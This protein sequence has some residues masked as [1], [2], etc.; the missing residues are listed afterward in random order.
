MLLYRKSSASVLKFVFCIKHYTST[1]AV[2]RLETK[3]KM[4]RNFVEKMHHNYL[5]E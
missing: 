1:D 2:I 3:E 5:E 4:T